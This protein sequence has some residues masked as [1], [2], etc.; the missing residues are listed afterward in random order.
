MCALQRCHSKVADGV[1]GERDPHEN[2]KVKTV[3]ILKTLFT[4]V[5]HLPISAL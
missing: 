1:S 4:I 5:S 2:E 3:C